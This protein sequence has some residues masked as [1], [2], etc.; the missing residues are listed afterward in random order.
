MVRSIADI[1]GV[2]TACDSGV[3]SFFYNGAPVGKQRDLVGML[4]EFQNKVVV[5]H[6]AI[7]LQPPADL[8]QIHGPRVLMNLHGIS[9]A[10]RDMRPTLPPEVHEIVLCASGA[11]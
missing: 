9:S 5:P 11:I 8:R 10:Q 6:R 2:E 4:L 1:A 3:G 7:V